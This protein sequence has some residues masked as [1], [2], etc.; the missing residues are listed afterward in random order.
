MPQFPPEQD[1][2]VVVSSEPDGEGGRR[3]RLEPGS[4]EDE[5]LELD[6]GGIRHEDDLVAAMKEQGYTLTMVGGGSRSDEV[7]RFYFRETG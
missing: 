6:T 1:D 3:F 2:V 7:R 4:G 5:E